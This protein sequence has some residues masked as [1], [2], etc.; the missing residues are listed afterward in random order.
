M[1]ESVRLQT[2]SSGPASGSWIAIPSPDPA[3]KARGWLA[4]ARTEREGTCKV[5][6]RRAETSEVLPWGSVA[7]AVM[8]GSP[9]GAVK[10]T[11][12][13]TPPVAS[14]VTSSEPR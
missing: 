3:A 1:T 2:G 11:A 14:V 5:A 10:G 12:K 13:L 4:T 6:R 7:V 9:A 8:I